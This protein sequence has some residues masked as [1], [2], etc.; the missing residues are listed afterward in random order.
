MNDTEIQ[1]STTGESELQFVSFLI[2]GEK[3]AFPMNSVGE[4]IRVPSMVGVPLGTPQM[5]GLANLRGNVLPV[6]DL[7]VV[8]LGERTASTD[9]SR[10]VVVESSLGVTGFLVDKVNR[11]YSVSKDSVVKEQAKES[12]IAYEFLDG[13]IR[14]NGEPLE[15]ILNVDLL[16]KAQ[17]HVV[18]GD[19][20]SNIA[21]NGLR[22]ADSHLEPDDIEEQHQLVCFSI[23]EQ[24]FAFSLNDVGEIVRVP[25]NIS[26]LPDSHSSVLGLV[27]LRGRIIPIVDLASNLGLPRAH[28]ND[29][30]RIIIVH[31][32]SAELGSV[33]LVVARVR[34][35]ISISPDALEAI[36]AMCNDGYSDGA[37]ES[38]Y[39]DESSRK[40]ISILN[41]NGIFS[42]SLRRSLEETTSQSEADAM[43]TQNEALIAEEDYQQYVIFYID[44]QEYGVGIEDTQEI[45]RVPDSLESVPNTP[46]YLQ[47]IVN[48]RGTVLPV[49]DLRCRLGLV[50]AEQ[51][52]RQRII[53]LTRDNQKTGFIVDGVAEVK[54][55]VSKTIESAPALSD[56]KSEMLN[57]LI[58]L[59][60]EQRIIQ[61]LEPSVLLSDSAVSS[62]TAG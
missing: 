24:D 58:K 21:L 49:I 45:T 51:T 8:L 13:L 41:L 52:D 26:A 22:K 4:I 42:R 25:D 6:Y 62:M 27:N 32:H 5:L 20:D 35:V 3:F 36:P 43:Q 14:Q 38:V 55:V 56:E 44:G 19:S 15:Q 28:I 1:E 53:V 57:R 10:V 60:D 30:S 29:A 47:G 9:S 23:A 17:L 46:D 61:L 40:L 18:S 54:T 39:R 50:T 16:V 31:S 12:A 7:R 34:N 48:L 11:V 2:G 37:L 59:D 33:G